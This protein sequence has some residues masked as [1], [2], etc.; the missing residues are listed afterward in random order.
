MK[1]R[2]GRMDGG[3]ARMGQGE[4]RQKQGEGDAGGNGE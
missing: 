4:T 1:W 3:K 2:S